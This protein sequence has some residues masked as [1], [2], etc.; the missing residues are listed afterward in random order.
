MSGEARLA[1][2]RGYLWL[3]GNREY[4]GLLISSLVS[5]LGDQ[6]ARVALVVLVYERTHSPLLSS[7]T[8][9][10]T[11]LPVVIGAPLLG[12]LADRLPRRRVLVA[13]DLICAGFFALMAVSGLPVWVLLVLLLCAVTVE[14]PWSAARGPLIRE[15]L[16]DDEGYQRGTSLDEALYQGGQIVGFVAAGVL[17]VVFTPS[18]ALLLDAVSFVGSALAVRLLVRHR[19]A[20]DVTV[21]EEA[22]P[23]ARRTRRWTRTMRT[24]FADARL[25]FRV[26]MAPGCRRPLLLTWAGISLSI[27]PEA[28]AVPWADQVGAGAVGIGL[29]F[30][31]SPAGSIVGMLL[32]GRLSVE[33]GQRL[34]VPLA[35]LAL[36]PLLLAPAGLFLSWVLVVAFLSGVG[37]TYSLLAR[38]AFVRGVENAHRGP[39]LRCGRRRCYGRSR[40]RH[41]ASRRRGFPHQPGDVNRLDRRSGIVTRRHRRHHYT[42]LRA[43]CGG[44]DG[45]RTHWGP[46]PPAPH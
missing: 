32:F 8:Y 25:G 37:T 30:A 15:I 7:A 13:A 34:L 41:C 38:V 40:T 31:A 4:V 36:V 44:S 16:L 18:T 5:L 29:I 43:A 46:R 19:G 3:L 22:G 6:L 24:G 35:L 11:F 9:A 10:T 23:E 26:A 2:R 39:R 27:A 20:A 42:N 33:R 12:G 1:R 14:A 45:G 21:D 17:L 28:L